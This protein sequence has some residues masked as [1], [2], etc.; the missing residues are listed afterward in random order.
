MLLEVLFLLASLVLIYLCALFVASE[1]S[2]VTV[3]RATVCDEA[4]AGSKRAYGLEKALRRLSTHLSAAQIGITVT[5]LLIGFLAEPS[6]SR[7]IA[8]PL[9]SLA[10]SDDL[11]TGL[12]FFTAFILANI[13]TMLFGELVPKNIAIAKPLATAKA[14]QGFQRGFSY[15][16]YPLLSLSNG[17]ANKTLIRLGIE[18][19]EELAFA[20]SAE[21]L[22]SLVKRSAAEGTLDLPTARLLEQTLEFSERNAEDAMTPRSRVRTIKEGDSIYNL[23]LLVIRSGRSRFPVMR[24]DEVVGLAHLKHALAI[25]R[26]ERKDRVVAEIIKEAVMVPSSLDLDILLA[27]LRQESMQL[28]VV[29]D[30]FG[31]FHGVV[32][33]EDLVEEIVGEVHDEHDGN[34]VDV[35]QLSE[36]EWEVPGL[37]RPDEVFRKTGIELPEDRDYETVAG[38]MVDH[39]ERIPRLRDSV[40]VIGQDSE[41]SEV[42]VFLRVQRMDGM[43]IDRVYVRSHAST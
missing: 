17:L 39:L 11:I 10:L 16:I 29:V 42:D 23:L 2:F 3:D 19:Q 22:Q 25:P 31:S 4:K 13:L 12:A 7:I 35:V 26:S 18:P 6:L 38:L 1:F 37:L 27:R 36:N 14:V 30:E 8:R 34:D 28:A 32:T 24:D 33:L 43:R 5:N 41:G 9:S 20:R 40:R 21:E 15:L